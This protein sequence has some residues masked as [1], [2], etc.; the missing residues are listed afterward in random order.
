MLSKYLLRS[1][2]VRKPQPLKKQQQGATTHVLKFVSST[3]VRKQTLY[4][5]TKTRTFN[6]RVLGPVVG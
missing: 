3:V 5:C 1:S 6:S 4:L 2:T